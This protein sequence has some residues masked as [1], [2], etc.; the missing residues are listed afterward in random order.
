MR[1]TLGLLLV[2]LIAF[3]G[4]AL[5]S[6]EEQHSA[7][8]VIAGSNATPEYPPAALAAGFEGS[9]TV[10]AVVYEDGSTGAVEVVDSSSPK[11]GFEQAALE[12]FG[13]W[14]FAPATQ[15]GEP[16]MSVWA[17]SFHFSAPGGRL[18]PSPYVSGDFVVSVLAG[19]GALA[20]SK[21]GADDGRITTNA[22]KG[23]RFE[24][25]TPNKIPCR[26]VGCM[27]DRSLLLGPQQRS[28]PSG[29][30]H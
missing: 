28:A 10:A 27:Y 18:N 30:P 17:Y 20:G 8:F 16:V 21:G 11:L 3:T 12:A 5:A 4:L 1:R 9:V 15:D 24:P 13:H 22:K 23:R 6:D 25:S 19:P 2:V 14:Q 26:S 7:A 29:A